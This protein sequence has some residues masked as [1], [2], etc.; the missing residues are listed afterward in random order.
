MIQVSGLTKDYGLTRAVD[1]ISFK[2][3]KGE[4]VGLLGPNGAGK[5]T[6][7]K[8]LTTYLAPTLGSA[9]VDGHDTLESPMEVRRRIGY[10]PENAPIYPEFMVSDYLEFVAE[11]RGIPASARADAIRKAVRV[12]GLAPMMG[13]L[14]GE[15]SKGYRQRTG[16]AQALLHDPEILILD[17]PT[18]GLDPN[19]IVEVRE[20]IKEIGARKTVILS[21]HILPEVQ[22]TCDRVII[23]SRGKV[24][25]D[26]KTDELTRQTTGESRLHVTLK[27]ESRFEDKLRSLSGV[28]RIERHPG[29][30]GETTLVLTSPAGLDLREAVYQRCV[31]EKLT[32]LELKQEQKSLEHIFSQLT[33]A[34][35]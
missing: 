21:T 30:P 13:R 35:A 18:S 6:T 10:L 31:E 33:Q 15:L 19:Q 32:L 34:T 24:V 5:S 1:N 16:L 23:I 26:G 2:I 29:S 25:A 9:S 28:G 12:T 17:E 27:G 20:V 7:M 14:V 3:E 8:M 4:V 11:V 22:A